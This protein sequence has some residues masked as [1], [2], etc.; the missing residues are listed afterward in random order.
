MQRTEDLKGGEVWEGLDSGN[1]WA[2]A[3]RWDYA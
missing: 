3:Q 1:N 2:K